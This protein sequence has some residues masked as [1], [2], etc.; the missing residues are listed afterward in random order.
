[1]N[2]SLNWFEFCPEFCTFCL[3]VMIT[4]ETNNCQ[5]THLSEWYKLL[6]IF[7]I[8]L[9]LFH[10]KSIWHHIRN[11]KKQQKKSETKSHICLSFHSQGLRSSPTNIIYFTSVTSSLNR[12]SCVS[13]TSL[14]RLCAPFSHS[15]PNVL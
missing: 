10:R 7:Y 5:M 1:M 14:P 13:I 11:H 9:Y 3:F 2:I 4:F 12:K 6:H 8:I 15:M